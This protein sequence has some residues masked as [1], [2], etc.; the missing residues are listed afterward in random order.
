MGGRCRGRPVGLV[1]TSR[2]CGR[3]VVGGGHISIGCRSGGPFPYV[4][5]G[6]RWGS[7]RRGFHH[8]RRIHSRCSVASCVDVVGILCRPVVVAVVVA[9]PPLLVG[10]WYH[11]GGR[12][13]WVLKGW[14]LGSE[15]S[16]RFC[17]ILLVTEFQSGE[18]AL[19]LAYFG[20]GCCR[21]FGILHN[22]FGQ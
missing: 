8:G 10:R 2:C 15:I 22:A 16:C 9:P 1:G 11:N 14:C 3:F 7:R 4:G 21:S 5:C 17:C 20:F 13:R 18:A 6:G 19:E 12:G